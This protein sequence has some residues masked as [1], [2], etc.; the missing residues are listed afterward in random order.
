MDG[1]SELKALFASQKL[2]VLATQSHGQPHGCLVA[3]AASD[4]L[5]YLVFATDRDTR[6]YRDIRV[7]PRVALLIDSRQNQESDFAETL[8]VTA[9]GRA[10]EVEGRERD[11]CRR[12]YLAKH[13]YL[14]GFID[15]PGVALIQ[16]RVEEY[17]AA[18]FRKTWVLRPVQ[19][20]A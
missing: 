6:K 7:S 13:P 4:D 14:R 10:A 5:T 1:I 12:L 9:R 17:L 16:V 20:D 15:R 11:E 18:T 8:A 3:F 19:S 2:A